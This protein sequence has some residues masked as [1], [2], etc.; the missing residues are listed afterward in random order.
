VQIHIQRNKVA[1]YNKGTS[2][3]ISEQVHGLS[4]EVVEES[5]GA[6]GRH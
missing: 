3:V 6:G 2:V 1:G 4:K 5:P